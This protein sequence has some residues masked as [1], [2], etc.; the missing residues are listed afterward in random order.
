MAW[1]TTVG[2][3]NP[4]NTRKTDGAVAT[5]FSVEDTASPSLSLK[6]WFTNKTGDAPFAGQII[7]ETLDAESGIEVHGTSTIYTAQKLFAD[8]YVICVTGCWGWRK[9]VQKFWHEQANT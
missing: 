9:T 1:M 8:C 2:A 3:V 6:R 7:Q 5:V 4:T